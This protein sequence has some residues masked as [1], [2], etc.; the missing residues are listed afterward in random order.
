MSARVLRLALVLA[1]LA[2]PWLGVA[3]AAAQA[4]STDAL[5]RARELIKNADYDQALE[6]LR[7][8]IAR[9]GIPTETLREAY[10]QLIK[11]YVF[12]GNDYKFRPQG[13]EASNLNYRA[14]RDQIAALLAI[15]ALRDTRPEPAT[16]YPPEMIGFFAEVRSRMFGGFRVIG[17]EPRIAVVMLDGDT[18]GMSDAGML[19]SAIDLPVGPH[20]V[21]VRAPGHEDLVETITISPGATVE[22]SYRLEKRRT[23][24]W[25]ATRWGG[26]AVVVGG[27][28]ALLARGSSDD[29]AS[30]LPGPPPPP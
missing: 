11:T 21:S 23:A 22:R 12:L 8:E 5:T 26:A 4:A 16:D 25:Y 20:P 19:P 10:L 15:P 6:V 9:P 3:P 2:T 1:T 29:A 17:L 28:V 30:P 13:R 24:A 18:L 7:A 27:V 14:A